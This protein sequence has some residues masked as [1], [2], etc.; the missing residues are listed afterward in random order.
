MLLSVSAPPSKDKGIA[1]ATLLQ[2][3]AASPSQWMVA[4]K[5]PP[6]I[7]STVT[8]GGNGPSKWCRDEAHPQ[9]RR[10]IFYSLPAHEKVFVKKS[11][12][13]SLLC[14]RDHPAAHLLRPELQLG[15][16]R[17]QVIGAGHDRPVRRG[18][19]GLQQLDAT[20]LGSLRKS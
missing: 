16:V 19:P 9:V 7:V 20:Q 18:L 13:W 10:S 8:C 5:A 15:P 3:C 1:Q 2:D 12:A 11:L 14:G 17:G 6:T 4:P